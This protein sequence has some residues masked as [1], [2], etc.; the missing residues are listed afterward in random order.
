MAGQT[1]GCG[2]GVGVGVGGGGGCTADPVGPHTQVH[3][4]LAD[5]RQGQGSGVG[6]RDG[7][8]G[9]VSVS[10]EAEAE[11]EAAA[12]CSYTAAPAQMLQFLSVNLR[13]HRVIIQAGS[14]N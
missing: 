5:G 9:V 12:P 11:A 6:G 7:P 10:A 14:R 13:V 2:V 3:G 1:L 4:D 8:S